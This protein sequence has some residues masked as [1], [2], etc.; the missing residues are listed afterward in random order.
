MIVE[1][2]EDCKPVLLDTNVLCQIWLHL[3]S[4]HLQQNLCMSFS[5]AH[6][7]QVDWSIWK[8]FSHVLV[9][10]LMDNKNRG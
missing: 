10:L 9:D 8:P 3:V 5:T 6:V 4:A 2:I 7:S 1:F